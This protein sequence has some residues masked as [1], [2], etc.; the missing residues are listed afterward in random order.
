MTLQNLTNS[1]RNKRLP[2]I[3][4]KELEGQDQTQIAKDLGVSRM[5]IWEDRQ[6]PLYLD[7]VINFWDKYKGKIEEFMESGSPSAQIEALKELGRMYRAGTTKRIESKNLSVQV[8]LGERRGGSSWIGE[9]TPQEYESFIKL[10][11]RGRAR[12]MDIKASQ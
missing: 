5:T 6:D 10:R 2:K 7:L 3:F 9:L 4:L 11:D 1:K 8:Q 12:V